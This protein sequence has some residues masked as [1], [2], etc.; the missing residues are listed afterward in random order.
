MKRASGIFLHPTSLPSRFGVGDFGENAYRWIDCLAGNRQRYWQICPLGPTGY[1][2][3]PYQCLCSFA[4]N[5]LLISPSRLLDLG[6]LTSEELGAFPALPDAAVDYGKVIAEKDRIFEKAYNRFNDTEAFVAFCER[7]RYWLDDFALF[8]VIKEKHGGRSWAEW[9]PPYRLRFPAALD[10]LRSEKRRAVRYQKFLQFVF[11]TQWNGIRVYAKSK[12]VS[13]I[14]DMPIY[15]A[16]DSS[17]TWGSPELFELDEKGNPLRVAGVPPDYFSA[18]GQLWG[19]PLYQWG[20]M[21]QDGYAWWIKRIRKMLEL[22]DYLRLDHFR[23]FDSYWAIPAG[24]A[25]AVNGTWEPGPGE[26]FFTAVRHALGA[27]PLIA[28]DLGEITRGVE[29]LRRKVG[30]PG[31]KV[32]QFAFDGDPENPYLPCNV[33][34]DSVMYTGTHDN[35]TSCGW[36]AGLGREERRYVARYL[37][38]TERTFIDRFLRCAYMSPSLLCIIPAQD[39]LGLD[40]GNRMN[41]PGTESGNWQW[42]M[43]PEHLHPEHFAVAGEFTEVYGRDTGGASSAYAPAV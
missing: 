31:M 30:V 20:N 8:Q 38:C 29:Q 24:S 42:R 6:L 28:E 12:G 10:E 22:V 14:G 23:G 37:G 4:G 16:Y 39:L 11:H 17:D 32:L 43:L 9:E 27:V 19:N 33:N 13:I 7:E 2:D 21:R 5:R 26:G 40:A 35:N 1:G 25:T 34:A 36:Y 18:T 15:V 3:S 41:T